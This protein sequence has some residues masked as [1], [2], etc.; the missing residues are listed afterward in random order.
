[1]R[2]T[3]VSGKDL[4]SLKFAIR[5]SNIRKASADRVGKAAS[6][7]GHQPNGRVYLRRGTVY[8]TDYVRQ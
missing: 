1:M 5:L 8:A 2:V 7:I 4:A 6:L 3:S